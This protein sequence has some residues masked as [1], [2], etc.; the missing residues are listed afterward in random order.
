MGPKKVRAGVSGASREP[1]P[2]YPSKEPVAM[3]RGSQE[4]ALLRRGLAMALQWEKVMTAEKTRLIRR[5]AEAELRAALWGSSASEAGAA[6]LSESPSSLSQPQPDAVPSVP[7]GGSSNSLGKVPAV[8]VLS[9]PEGGSSDSPGK[10]PAMGALSVPEGWSSDSPGKVPATGEGRVPVSRQS[11][12]L[13]SV[14]AVQSATGGGY[15]DSPGKAPGQA[16]QSATG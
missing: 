1:S 4:V 15:S 3:A 8:A 12:D 14:M 9:V 11:Q 13:K 16:V 2:P 6:A 10:D 7:E 5:K